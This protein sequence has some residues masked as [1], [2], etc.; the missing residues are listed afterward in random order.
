MCG[1]RQAGRRHQR[2]RGRGDSRVCVVVVVGGG[3]GG[4]G[5]P[6][7]CIAIGY[8]SFRLVGGGEPLDAVR[9]PVWVG[10]GVGGLGFFELFGGF[11]GIVAGL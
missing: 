7:A 4:L 11:S 6:R 5:L 9:L 10:G 2:P 1:E 3:G 8:F